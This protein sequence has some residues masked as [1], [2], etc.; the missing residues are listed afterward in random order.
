MGWIN[1]FTRKCIFC[2]SKENTEYIEAYGM[3]G[4]TYSGNWYHKGCL[5]EVTCRPEKYPSLTVDMAIDIIDRI[6][7]K[8]RIRNDTIRQ[9]KEK[10]KY[11][12]S[13]CEEID[14]L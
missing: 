10:C 2:K 6:K 11:L 9:A 12:S 14:K 4:E 3:Y 1:Y 7:R 5:H 13:I 8:E